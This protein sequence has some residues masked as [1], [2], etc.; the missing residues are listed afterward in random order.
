MSPEAASASADNDGLSRRNV[1][2]GLGALA[3][4]GTAFAALSS[5]AGATAPAYAPAATPEALASPIPGLTYLN[6]DAQAFWPELGMAAGTPATA[7]RVYQ[8]ATGSQ[9]G[10]TPSRLWAPLPLPVGSVIR[11]ISAAYQ[12]LAVVDI[13]KRPLFSTGGPGTAPASQFLATFP[14]SPGGSL[15]ATLNVDPP[16]TLAGDATY[17]IS[18]FCSSSTSVFGVS[19]GYVPP[20]QSFIPFTGPTPRVLDTRDPGQIRFI[21]NEQRK[22]DLGQPGARSGVFNLTVVNT[23]GNV[24]GSPAGGFASA[25]A[26]DTFPGNSSVNWDH[27]GQIS[28]NLVISALDQTGAVTIRVGVNRADV[29]IDRIGFLI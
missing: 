5:S 25:F 24:N 27:P 18:A 22:I 8:D 28:A 3:G 17:T 4:A 29:I 20:T 10:A 6:I 14:Q 26:G 23:E 2:L 1:L 15:A 11:H 21:P 16:V 7:Q 13:M 9:P 19:I 12:G